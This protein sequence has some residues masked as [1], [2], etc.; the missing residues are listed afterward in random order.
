MPNIIPSAPADDI[1]PTS[2]REAAKARVRAKIAADKARPAS[3]QLMNLLHAT[4]TT[5]DSQALLDAFRAEVLHEAADAVA[6]N[7][8]GTPEYG[9]YLAEF[10]RGMANG[11]AS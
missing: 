2:A 4:R 8:K 11:G 1:N 6:E 7:L 3:E 9:Q 10:L 5:A